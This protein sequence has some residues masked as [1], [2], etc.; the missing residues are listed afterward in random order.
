ML[1]QISRKGK[2]NSDSE[3]TGKKGIIKGRQFGKRILQ[4]V[5]YRLTGQLGLL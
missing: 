5:V 2:R 4:T 3:S 1:N